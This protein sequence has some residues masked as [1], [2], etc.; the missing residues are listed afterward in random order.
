[1]RFGGSVIL[2]LQLCY[3]NIIRMVRIRFNFEKG[4]DA[5]KAAY[6]VVA[7]VV[8]AIQSGVKLARQSTI[9]SEV[10]KNEPGSSAMS[11]CLMR[12]TTATI[13]VYNHYY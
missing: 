3:A 2:S 10:R 6:A 7:A 12:N 5:T 8:V 11:L 9:R 1:M 4:P 13:I